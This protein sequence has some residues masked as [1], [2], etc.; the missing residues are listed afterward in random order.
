MSDDKVPEEKKEEYKSY[1]E[2]K[3]ENDNASRDLEV[4]GLSGSLLPGVTLQQL[5]AR[6]ATR[7]L[8]QQLT[9][10]NPGTRSQKVSNGRIKR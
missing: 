2:K 4:S 9:E 1:L 3:S 5:L 10:T 7:H 8:P 6:S